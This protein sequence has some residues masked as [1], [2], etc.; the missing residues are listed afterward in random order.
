MQTILVPVDFSTT[1]KNAAVYAAGLAGEMNCKKIILYHAYQV[2]VSTDASMGAV[3]LVGMN[4]ISKGSKEGLELAAN[5][6]RGIC[7][8]DIAIDTVSECSLLIS[9]IID[10]SKKNKVDLIVMGITGGDKLEEVIIGSNAV[11]VAKHAEVPVIIV[12]ADA[13]FT[14]IKNIL[15]ACD[16]KKV[17]ETTPVEPIKKMLDATDAKLFVLNVDSENKGFSAE[18]PFESL[19]LDTLLHGYN[20]E[21]HFMDGTDFTQAINRFAVDNNIDLIITIPKKHGLFEGLFKRSHTKALAFH[22]HV[23]MMVVHE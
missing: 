18:T 20:P 19:M 3:D 17:A 1:A 9:G 23:P 14:E 16:F 4:E 12:P 13:K 22:T 21:Y 2:P 5:N 15:L 8:A 7:S 11:H 6:L 10:I